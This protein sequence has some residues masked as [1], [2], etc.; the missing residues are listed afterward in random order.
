MVCGTEL[1]PTQIIHPGGTQLDRENE[2]EERER[3]RDSQTDRD[4]ARSKNMTVHDNISVFHS[5]S[6]SVT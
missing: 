5:M 6:R 4:A 3:A 2:T 1:R